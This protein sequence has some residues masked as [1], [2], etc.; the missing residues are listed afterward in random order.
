MITSMSLL[1]AV[2]FYSI[3]FSSF[4]FFEHFY[5]YIY[6]IELSCPINQC[7]NG[8]KCSTRLNGNYSCQ[9]FSPYSGTNCQNG[10]LSFLILSFFLSYSFFF[11]SSKGG[12]DSNDQ[13]ILAN[14]YNS[15]TSKGTLIWNVIN[16]L[17][18]QSGVGCDS[19]NPKRIVQL[20][21]LFSF[22]SKKFWDCCPIIYEK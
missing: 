18:F 14:F 3:I 5:I 12:M 17:C 13:T 16:D 19:S 7:L 6:K 4:F 1:N 10:S 15:L 9:C 2:F 11:L 20:Y 22:I 21:F 8:G